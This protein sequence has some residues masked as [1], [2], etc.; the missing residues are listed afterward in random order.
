MPPRPRSRIARDVGDQVAE[1]LEALEAAAAI[2]QNIDLRPCRATTRAAIKVARVAAGEAVIAATEGMRS[3][4]MALGDSLQS[5]ED[6][7]G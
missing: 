4:V 1:A 7:E 3:E 5:P 6:A 2:L